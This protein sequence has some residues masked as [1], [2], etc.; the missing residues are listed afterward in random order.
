LT[1]ASVR[2]ESARSGFVA[3]VNTEEIGHAIAEAGGGRVRIEDRIDPAV[4]FINEVK[5]GDAVRAGELIG[6]VY[7]DDSSR[8][9]RAAERIQTA[10][11]IDDAP[12]T[13]LAFLI[14]EVIED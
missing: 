6:L 4:G 2:V 9:R 10:Y 7:C 5:I 14:K 12:P 13:E 8:G 11:E 1:D 3:K